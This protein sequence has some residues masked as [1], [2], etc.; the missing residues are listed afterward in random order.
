MPR[1]NLKVSVL[2]VLAFVSACVREKF[3]GP[4]GVNQSIPIPVEV[5][6]LLESSILSEKSTCHTFAASKN[7]LK[8]MLS[9]VAK[10]FGNVEEKFNAVK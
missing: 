2:S 10:T 1:L 4:T 5:L 3:S 6:I 7:I 9:C 8:S